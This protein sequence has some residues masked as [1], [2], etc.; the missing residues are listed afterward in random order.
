MTAPDK[1]LIVKNIASG[2]KEAEER[3]KKWEL[4]NNATSDLMA[5]IAKS[6][7]ENTD[8]KDLRI[9]MP[10]KPEKFVGIRSVNTEGYTYKMKASG[11]FIK[12]FMSSEGEEEHEKEV[13]EAL[14]T[15][16]DNVLSFCRKLSE[17]LKLFAIGEPWAEKKL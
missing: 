9:I 2:I 4:S 10:D 6:L 5:I 1:D 13:M 8:L 7:D 12:V 3:V 17:M 16:A 14:A 11:S 15:D